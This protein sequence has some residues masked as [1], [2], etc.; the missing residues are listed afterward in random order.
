MVIC[1]CPPS[2]P[3]SG[4]PAFLAGSSLWLGAG[5]ARG[6]RWGV[7]S[8]DRKGG[9]APKAEGGSAGESGSEEDA[10]QRLFRAGSRG[11]LG[12]GGGGSPPGWGRPLKT[13]SRRS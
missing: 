11:S 6:G 13:S 5:W 12:G 8:S 9:G 2:W 10:V 7:G 1:R 3:V 4:G